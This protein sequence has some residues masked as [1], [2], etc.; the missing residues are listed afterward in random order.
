MKTGK[1]V[2]GITGAVLALIVSQLAAQ[3]L[4]GL[5]AALH[6]PAALCNIAGGILYAVIAFLLLI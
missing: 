1:V 2:L 3:L 4:A 5:F 6:L